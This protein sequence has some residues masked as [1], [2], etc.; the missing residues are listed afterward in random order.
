M[1]YKVG[2][3]VVDPIFRGRGVVIAWES[4]SGHVGVRFDSYDDYV[5]EEGFHAVWPDDLISEQLHD[6]PLMKALG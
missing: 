4:S 2:D 6:S 1:K 3:R 5:T